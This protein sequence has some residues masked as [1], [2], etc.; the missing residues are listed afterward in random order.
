MIDG[1]IFDKD[2]TLFDFRK[3]WGGWSRR[4]LEAL[5]DDPQRRHAMGR[6]IGYDL[7]TQ[8]FDAGSPVIAGTPDEIAAILL[9]LLPDMRPE[10]LIARMN[11]LAALAP[12]AEA[13]PLDA[14]LTRLR[15]RGVRIGL[16]TNDAEAPARAHLAAHDL[17]R[18]FDF[19]AGSDSGFGGKPAPGQLVAFC[20]ATG[21]D[22]SRIVMVGDS[23]HDLEA[24][25]RAGM[26]RVAV[27]TGIA[28]KAEL[29]PHADVV[30]ADIG[31]LPGWLD[32]L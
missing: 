25:R 10:A 26:H 4:L 16:A 13:V 20:R 3:S 30:L 22:P 5:S 8:D 27:L 12:M 19:I 7:D 21:L 17:T 2:G 14:L 29:A 9:P 23:C 6:A 32:S 1:I 24:G 15:E 28:G 31:A 18:H 11:A